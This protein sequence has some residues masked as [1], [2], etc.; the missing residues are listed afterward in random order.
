MH[1][2]PLAALSGAVACALGLTLTGI[3][4]NAY[5]VGQFRDAATAE[6]FTELNRPRLAPFA[7][8]IAHLADPRPYVLIGAAL[9]LVALLRGRWTV[10]VMVPLVLGGAGAT[11]ELLKHLL[12][13]PRSPEWFG[14]TT[15]AAASWPS[16]HATAA[17]ALALCAVMVAP[18]RLRPTVAALGG[19][20]AVA[21]SYSILML[22]WHFPSDVL[23]GFLVAA[24]W[25]LLAVAVVSAGRRRQ[26]EYPS[27]L[28]AQPGGVA[29]PAAV[30]T[31]AVGVVVGIVLTRPHVVTEY[32]SAHRTFVIGAAAI[33]LL[34]A[35]LAAAMLYAMSSRPGAY[36]R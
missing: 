16:G 34:A 15:I 8:R 24:M 10:A 32:A 20:F 5:P 33:P 4:A 6:G 28:L 31:A 1:R 26:S 27:G 3:I 14:K 19:G 12:A 11:A 7:D 9:V 35:V 13:H 23:G 36:S 17:M 29:A 30:V 22:G 21:V 25:T 2:S 18:P